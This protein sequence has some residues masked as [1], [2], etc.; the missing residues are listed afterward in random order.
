MATYILVYRLNHICVVFYVAF[1]YEKRC[2]NFSFKK[3]SVFFGDHL[4]ILCI[5]KIPLAACKVDEAGFGGE[6]V[7][8]SCLRGVKKPREIVIVVDPS[9]HLKKQQQK[10]RLRS[11]TNPKII[12]ICK[13]MNVQGSE[14]T[15]ELGKN[16]SVPCQAHL[17]RKAYVKCIFVYLTNKL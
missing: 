11:K 2:L 5:F 13:C 6:I 4:C 9:L 10:T 14:S 17:F 16:I 12:V 8:W 15:Q 3:I 1:I 7:W